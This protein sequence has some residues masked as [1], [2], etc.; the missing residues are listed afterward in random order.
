MSTSDVG[1]EL[2]ETKP[3]AWGRCTGIM[4]LMGASASARGVAAFRVARASILLLR[5]GKPPLKTWS[6]VTREVADM[7]G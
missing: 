6:Y 7:S 4:R 3:G 1:A 2:A 5:S